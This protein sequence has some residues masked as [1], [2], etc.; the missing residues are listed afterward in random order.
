MDRLIRID[1]RRPEV[2]E[3]AIEWIHGHEFW[4]SNVLSAPKLRAQF[5]TL[6]LQAERDRGKSQS[7]RLKSSGSIA[8][9]RRE[10][11]TPYGSTV[12][13]AKPYADNDNATATGTDDA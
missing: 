9:I 3:A 4:R 2:I 7:G 1:G 8:S 5:D 11:D 13:R 10:D 12:E 6:Y